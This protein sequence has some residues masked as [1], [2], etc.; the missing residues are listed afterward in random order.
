MGIENY[1]NIPDEN[2]QLFPE[3]Q[4]PSTVNDGI[5]QIQT[6]LSNWYRDPWWIEYGNGAGLGSGASSYIAEQLTANSFRVV[7]TNVEAVYHP[8]R[9][10][11]LFGAS[12]DLAFGVIVSSTFTGSQTEVTVALEDAATLAFEQL[13]VWIGL[14]VVDPS[15]SSALLTGQAHD[16]N[17]AELRRP[18]VRDARSRVV[19]AAPSASVVA[20]DLSLGDIFKSTLNQGV[21]L[22]ITN[23]AATDGRGFIW[24][25]SQDATG[26]RQIAWPANFRWPGAAAPLLSTGALARDRFA[27][28]SEDAGATV[29]G[30]T[31]GK[32][33]A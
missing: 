17:G 2:T 12:L 31:I 21:T 1:S 24:V 3:L 23:W 16:F 14:P 27:F 18:L 28:F 5:R 20:I 32:A 15:W 10:V 26:G 8:G 4:L 29:D 6:D 30:I 19:T 11:R 22:N 33:F 9:R 7:G 13:R 25:A